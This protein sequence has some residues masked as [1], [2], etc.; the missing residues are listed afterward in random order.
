MSFSTRPDVSDE[1]N[2]VPPPPLT[3][4]EAAYEAAFPN[5]NRTP[6]LQQQQEKQESITNTTTTTTVT[7]SNVNVRT[8]NSSLP[9]T[10][11]SSPRP[12]YSHPR[13]LVVD[14][15]NPPIRSPSVVSSSAGVGASDTSSQRTGIPASRGSAGLTPHGSRPPV[16][17]SRGPHPQPNRL[18]SCFKPPQTPSSIFDLQLTSLVDTYK[19]LPAFLDL[20][21]EYLCQHL[22]ESSEFFTPVSELKLQDYINYLEDAGEGE[23]QLASI[24]YYGVSA[25]GGFL[26]RFLDTIPEPLLTYTRYE[27]FNQAANFTPIG[28]DGSSAGTTQRHVAGGIGALSPH[29]PS[30]ALRQSFPVLT[31]CDEHDQ[32][33]LL[34]SLVISL[35]GAHFLLL[36]RLVNL[37]KRIVDYTATMSPSPH[38]HGVS[39]QRLSLTLSHSIL[40]PRFEPGSKGGESHRRAQEQQ[41]LI[42]L[43][44]HYDAIFHTNPIR[45]L[46]CAPQ[47]ST[48]IIDP[49]PELETTLTKWR[50]MA[51]RLKLNFS[52]RHF[53]VKILV[54]AFRGWRGTIKTNRRVRKQWKHRERGTKGEPR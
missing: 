51:G 10:R 23:I 20:S 36:E 27:Q 48:T 12:N 13:P 49:N 21:I 6:R 31:L 4:P 47:G 50:H 7:Q 46:S 11:V 5:G 1:K 54:K 22:D 19:R 29:S 18:M 24:G 52:R 30:P 41:V 15:D 35:P 14:N 17:T 45:L 2:G 3:S 53:D 42:Y 37:L 33:L 32:R 38:V 16:P 44:Q 43:V 39:L 26:K 40:T 28:G 34:Q 9:P 8:S 25:I